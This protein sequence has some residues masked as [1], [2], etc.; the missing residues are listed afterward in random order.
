VLVV[1]LVVVLA[2]LDVVE[3]VESV[4]LDIASSLS[5]LG[6]GVG[7]GLIVV[8]GREYVPLTTLLVV[9]TETIASPMRIAP[10]LADGSSTF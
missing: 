4:V 9:T 8:S 6:V 7:V 3:S 5:I 10:S 2:V 1:V